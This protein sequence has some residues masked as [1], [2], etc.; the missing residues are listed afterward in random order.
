[1]PFP[2]HLVLKPNVVKTTFSALMWARNFLMDAIN[3]ACPLAPWWVSA[4]AEQPAVSKELLPG[5]E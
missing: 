5:M 3:I 1:M 2:L 4:L